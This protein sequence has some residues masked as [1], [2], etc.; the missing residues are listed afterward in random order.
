MV[1]L[2]NNKT[3]TINYRLASGLNVGRKV[4]VSEKRTKFFGIKKYMIVKWYNNQ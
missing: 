3:V 4:K 2:D 1:K